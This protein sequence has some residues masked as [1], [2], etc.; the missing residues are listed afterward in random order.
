MHKIVPLLLLI[1]LFGVG[2]GAA[3]ASDKVW[4][5]LYLAENT[6]PV[7]SAKEA[8][9]HLRHRLH[10]VFGYRHYYLVNGQV[11]DL[12]HAWEHWVM[13]RKD[14]FMRVQ[15][16]PRA[17]EDEPR[18]IYYEIYKDGFMVANGQYEAHEETPLFINGPDFKSG[19]FVFVI[20]SKN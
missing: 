2:S 18:R 5:G 9:E 7:E 4:A 20:E 14:L 17:K 8:P 13:P 1:A 16:L 12:H 15:P 10:A 3:S 6:K 19:R 11:I